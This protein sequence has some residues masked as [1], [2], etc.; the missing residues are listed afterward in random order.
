MGRHRTT[1]T[2]QSPTYEYRDWQRAHGPAP[3][4]PQPTCSL[5]G[6][7]HSTTYSITV[8]AVNGIGTG[9]ASA[10]L[11]ATT[12]EARCRRPVP[13][14]VVATP[15]G[16]TGVDLT[17]RAPASEMGSAITRYEICVIDDDGVALPFEATDGPALTWRVRGLAFNHRYGFRVRAV[18]SAGTG[19]Q[20]AL[21]YAMPMRPAVPVVASGQRIPLLDLDRQSLIVRLA[22][23]DCRIR[24]WWQPRDGAW[25]G[26]IEVPTNSLIIDG[27]RLA[28]GAGLLD[29]LTDVLPGNV[30]C[31]A[32]DQDSG[33]TDPARDAWRR[34]TH[35]L[36]WEA[37]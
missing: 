2:T 18:N 11:L 5:A 36:Y 19:P 29:R 8:R 24:V 1:A 6:C 14:F 13:L 20:T 37:D 10:A 27:R 33:L 26:S 22:G 12:S 15:T 28:T 32:I 25:Y 21:V 7:S 34:A 17:W 31:R 16:G 9:P 23:V 30:V 3:A 35:G 4:P